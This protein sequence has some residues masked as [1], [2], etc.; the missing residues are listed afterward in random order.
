M[1]TAIAKM[2]AT[3]AVFVAKWLL[4]GAQAMV[5]AAKVA[6]AWLLSTGAALATATGKMIATSAVFVAKWTLMAVQALA[7][8]ARMAAAWF[9]ALGPIGWVTA[10]VIALAVLVIANWDKIKAATSKIWSSIS[11]AV[12]DAWSKTKQNTKEALAAVVTIIGQ[13][14]GKVLAF[15]SEMLSAGADLIRGLISG[16]KNMAG[17]AIE[18]I[19]G[20]VGGVIGKARSLLQINS[21]SR[22]FE[23]FGGFLPHGL[24]NGIHDKAKM[25]V[26]AVAAMSNSITRAFSPELQMAG[27]NVSR[28][29]M[30]VGS[31][32]DQLGAQIERRIDL[33][34][35]V[36]HSGST[37]SGGGTVIHNHH[38]SINAKDIREMNDVIRLFDK[39]KIRQQ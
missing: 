2:G 38:Y 35:D 9:I 21:P 12:K 39:Q 19:S 36:N 30:D 27:V 20:V 25:A 31:Q 7:Q 11:N 10:A 4:I 17:S 8:A 26:N 16:I 32:M 22:I 24:A 15:K 13:L 33:E 5:H 18:A 6:A 23:A 1:A 29:S 28:S 37:S 3:A 34:M 14:P